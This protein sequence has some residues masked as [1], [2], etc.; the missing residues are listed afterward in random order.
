MIERCY[1]TIVRLVYPNGII[2]FAYMLTHIRDSNYE[3]SVYLDAWYK[4]KAW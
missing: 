4:V 3:I 2:K 1:G